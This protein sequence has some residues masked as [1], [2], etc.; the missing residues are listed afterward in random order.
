MSCSASRPVKKITDEDRMRYE[1][2]QF[3]RKK[4][5]TDAGSLF[6]YAQEAADNTQKDR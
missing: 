6:P 3:F 2:G 4:R 5:G 1:G